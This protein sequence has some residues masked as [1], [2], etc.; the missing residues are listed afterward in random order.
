[1]SAEAKT[2]QPGGKEGT[3]VRPKGNHLTTHRGDPILR[4]KWQRKKPKK[5][6]IFQTAI[7][8]GLF[9]YFG[10]IPKLFQNELGEFIT[11]QEKR[12]NLKKGGSCPC[13]LGTWKTATMWLSG[14][15]G[16]FVTKSLNTKY[17]LYIYIY[18]ESDLERLEGSS[19]SP[20]PV[21]LSP[22]K[23]MAAQPWRMEANNWNGHGNPELLEKSKNSPLPE[24][25]LWKT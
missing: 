17:K 24:T 22:L 1:M 14:I 25:N 5:G 18:R 7:H 10:G 16:C 20:K 21:C 15:F 11:L 4:K 19:K 3:V 13:P 2:R 23:E 12:R 8:H 6:L 9:E